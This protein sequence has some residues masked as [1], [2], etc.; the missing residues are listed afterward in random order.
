MMAGPAIIMRGLMLAG[1]AVAWGLLVWFGLK[2]FRFEREAF[3]LAIFG[4]NWPPEGLRDIAR[5]ILI[6]M[7]YGVMMAL[8]SPLERRRGMALR[9]LLALGLL[10]ALVIQIVRLGD[11]EDLPSIIDVVANGIGM[12]AAGVPA[13]VGAVLAN[14]VWQRFR[15]APLK[16]RRL[17]VAATA[18]LV[19]VAGVAAGRHYVVT[20]VFSA[21][22]DTLEAPVAGAFGPIGPRARTPRTLYYDS[23]GVP[24]P[25]GP[26]GALRGDMT[27]AGAIGPDL[28]IIHVADIRSL[29]RAVTRARPGQVISLAPGSYRLVRGLSLAR[30]GRPEAPIVLRAETSGTVTLRSIASEAVR[31]TAPY[32]VIEGVELRGACAADACEHAV[33]VT[34]KARGVTLRDLV[35]RD[36]SSPIKVNRSSGISPDNGLIEYAL[37][38]NGHPRVTDAAVKMVDIAAQGWRL[39]ASVIADFA[40]DGGDRTAYGVNLRGPNLV[41]RTLVACQWRHRGGLRIGIALG[42]EGGVVRN[43]IVSACPNEVGVDLD[44]AIGAVVHNSLIAGTRGLDLRRPGSSALVFNSVVD[45]GIRA[46][47]G[48]ALTAQD[49]ATSG[50]L[51]AV[52]GAV[53]APFSDDGEWFSGAGATPA[54]RPLPAPLPDICGG[55][56]SAR[57][58]PLGPFARPDS[59]AI[60]LP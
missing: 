24:L 55:M 23:A 10:T 40:R 7:P 14:I 36:F 56:M 20:R 9:A 16:A 8:R 60:R 50:W 35:I 48:G 45:G 12:V 34:G 54:G 31:V 2:P 25:T 11:P 52:T 15:R 30:A 53:S 28:E 39:H 37:I 42:G 1:L 38:F 22:A 58:P 13:A 17:G 51:A 46:R 5:N 32:W 6:A 33:H 18:A 27:A 26:D 44:G 19:L 57:Q 47:Q 21:A 59:C 49:N 43:S 3:D 29:L 41:E 4:L